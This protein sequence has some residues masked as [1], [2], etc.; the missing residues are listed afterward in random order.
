MFFH[1]PAGVEGGNEDRFEVC[2]ALLPNLPGVDL[3]L[4]RDHLFVGDTVDGGASFMLQRPNADG[5]V[6]PRWKG[7]RGESEQLDVDWP[8]QP[9]RSKMM[10]GTLPDEIPIG[11]KCGGV[12]FTIQ[13]AKEDY[14]AM[15]RKN[16]PYFVDPTTHKLLASCD[17]CD[18]CRLTSGTTPVYWISAL[19]KHVKFGR[20]SG[21]G[22]EN[23][24]PESASALEAAVTETRDRRFGSLAVY[25]S[26]NDGRRY[27]CSECSASI[28][29][30]KPSQPDVI[31][32]AI[33]VLQSPDGARAEGFL[34]WNYGAIG[35]MEDVS[36]GWREGVVGAMKRDAEDWRI[37]ME[38]PKCFRR[39]VKEKETCAITAN[40][41]SSGIKI[42]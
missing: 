31:D 34:T 40:T 30:T 1:F 36:N 15:E 42:S 41:R 38:I 11:C 2:A 4:I 24:L 29:Y 23:D 28:F 20:Q 10:K 18:S 27:S 17:V 6:V 5:V 22:V 16:L 3:I 33:G 19:L 37:K 14:A 13:R 35:Y 39:I 32:I 21:N 7:W 12:S 9:D 26:S 8:S 25:A